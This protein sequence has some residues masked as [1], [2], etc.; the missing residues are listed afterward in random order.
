VSG[1]FDAAVHVAAGL[2]GDRGS[3]PSRFGALKALGH[4]TGFPDP[5]SDRCAIPPSDLPASLT[6]SDRDGPHTAAVGAL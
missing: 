2:Y 3:G 1:L 5:V 4:F 6:A